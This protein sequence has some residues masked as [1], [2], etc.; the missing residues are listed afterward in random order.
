MPAIFAV[1]QIDLILTVPRKLAKITASVAGVRVVESPREIKSLSVFH[2]NPRL[3][4]EPLANDSLNNSDRLF[5]PAKQLCAGSSELGLKECG[6]MPAPIA[7]GLVSNLSS[8]SF[9]PKNRS[10]CGVELRGRF[11]CMLWSRDY[12]EGRSVSGLRYPS[13]RHVGSRV[14]ARVRSQL[15]TT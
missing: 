10:N 12:A 9:H 5:G 7:G 13:A 6:S 2:G 3:A 11:L 14:I 4:D 8:S 1:A 15:R